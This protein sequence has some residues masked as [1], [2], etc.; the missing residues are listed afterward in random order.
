MKEIQKTEKDKI[1]IVKQTSIEKQTVFLGTSRLKKGH[2]MFEVNYKE[3]TIVEA[4]FDGIPVLKF[5]DAKNGNV[6]CS[7]KITKKPDCIYVGALNKAN[8]LKILKREVGLEI[9]L[10]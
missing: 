6:S 9:N 10:K 1:E 3:H 5:E 8:A 7:N 4:K 2:T